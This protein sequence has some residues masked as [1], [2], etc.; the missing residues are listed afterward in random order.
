MDIKHQESVRAWYRIALFKEL[1][2]IGTSSLLMC[3]ML[4]LRMIVSLNEYQDYADKIGVDLLFLAIIFS[5]VSINQ[6]HEKISVDLADNGIKYDK[7]SLVVFVQM[8]CFY[9]GMLFF[10]CLINL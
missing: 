9:A 8:I 4:V 3:V 7:S 2:V 6:S 1:V 10:I 5:L